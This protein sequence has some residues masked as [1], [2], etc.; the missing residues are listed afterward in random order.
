MKKLILLLVVSF[1]SIN[2]FS[3]PNA[4]AQKIYD[5]EKAFERLSAEKGINQ[6]FIEFMAPDGILFYPNPVNGREYWKSR[7]ASPA[8]L[9]WNPTYV[10]VS[11]NGV[12]AYSTGNSVY[13]AKGKDDANGFHGQYMSIWQRQPD[14]NFRAV[15]DVGITHGKPEKIET[16]WKSPPDMG[17]EMNAQKSTAADYVNTFF[18][19]AAREGLNKAYKIYAAE[20]V[21]ALR[22]EKFPIIGKDN[23]LAETKKDKSRIAFAKRSVFFGA[24]DMAYITNS[25]T[26]TKKDNSAEQGNFVQIWKLRGGKWQLV[27]D[28]FILV[29]PDKK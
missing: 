26:L 2:A 8:F 17:K 22:E 10:D 20:A 14:G 5:T 3:Q 29:P 9:T 13:R 19:V 28:V 1:I 23:L 27:M 21:R 7:P 16:E 24:A 15:L 25:Y 11:S 4:D 6:A 18:E 12:L